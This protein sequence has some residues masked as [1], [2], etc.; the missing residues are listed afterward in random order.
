MG[1]YYLFCVVL[2]LS[3]GTWWPTIV[4]Y[5]FFGVLLETLGI[6]SGFDVYPH[7]IIAVNWKPEYSPW[8]LHLILYHCSKFSSVVIEILV[9]W[10]FN[11]FFASP[12]CFFCYKSA[13]IS[14]VAL[15]SKL[16]NLIVNYWLFTWS[17]VVEKCSPHP[18]KERFFVT[19]SLMVL[20]LELILSTELFHRR[21]N[22]VRHPSLFGLDFS[23]LH[24]HYYSWFLH[25]TT[26]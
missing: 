15:F 19:W 10:Y 14:S 21:G 26:R 17:G 8:A 1:L 22:D 3:V 12:K 13:T 6:F 4:W 11:L 25:S 23:G 18:V 16:I 7:L 24:S 20:E 2:P 5:W 9:V